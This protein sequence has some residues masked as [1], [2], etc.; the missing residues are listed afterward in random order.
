MLGGSCWRREIRSPLL[1][2][3]DLFAVLAF[4]DLFPEEEEENSDPQE[5]G[6]NVVASGKDEFQEPRC[7]QEVRGNTVVGDEPCSQENHQQS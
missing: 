3:A 2:L 1:P 4:P 7:L 5:Y 6:A